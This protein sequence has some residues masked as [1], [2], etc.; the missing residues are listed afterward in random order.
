MSSKVFVDHV[1]VTS[2]GRWTLSGFKDEARCGFETHRK[3]K[4]VKLDICH[5]ISR[6]QFP[7]LAQLWERNQNNNT[8]KCRVGCWFPGQARRQPPW[9]LATAAILRL[10]RPT[11][12]D[13]GAGGGH[14]P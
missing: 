5:S 14:H 4:G 10:L 9:E 13:T 2:V 3:A 1:H 7:E 8:N 12:W 11:A 6:G